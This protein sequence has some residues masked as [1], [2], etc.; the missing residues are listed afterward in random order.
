MHYFVSSI[1]IINMLLAIRKPL[2]NS[3]IRCTCL[4]FGVTR[5]QIDDERELSYGLQ[6]IFH[7][8]YI[9]LSKITVQCF[10]SINNEAWLRKKFAL[11]ESDCY[12]NYYPQQIR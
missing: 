9:N 2:N 12:T 11:A 6:Y 10:L 4:P 5:Y 3:E 1:F 7:I 8:K